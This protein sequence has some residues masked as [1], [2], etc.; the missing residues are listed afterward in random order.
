MPDVINN[1][2][3]K[4]RA[5]DN[6]HIG[7]LAQAVSGV[8]AGTSVAMALANAGSASAANAGSATA[9]PATPAGYFLCLGPNGTVV[10]VPYYAV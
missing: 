9:L 5:A 6:I 10:K 8:P 3:A 1:Q 4:Q 7:A 2:T